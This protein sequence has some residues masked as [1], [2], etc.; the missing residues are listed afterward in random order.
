MYMYSTATQML[1]SGKAGA[2]PIYI[3]TH[4]PYGII[5]SAD[6]TL[7]ITAIMIHGMIRG[8]VRHGAGAGVIIVR[9]GTFHGA[10]AGEEAS[11]GV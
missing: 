7:I 4:L 11:V 9:A 8:T 2:I 5:T 10:G 1:P 6:T 3:A